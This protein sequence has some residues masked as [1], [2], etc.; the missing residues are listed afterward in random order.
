MVVVGT[1]SN[2]DSLVRE[3]SVVLVFFHAPWCTV[4][5]SMEPMVEELGDGDTTVV[6]VD[7]NDEPG[8]GTRFSI[9]TLPCF[10]LYKDG[11]LIDQH[12]GSISKRNLD[13]FVLGGV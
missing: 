8:L 1:K 13:K 9:S 7:V 11:E 10:L 3:F 5:K 6:K 2:F 4:C 12:L